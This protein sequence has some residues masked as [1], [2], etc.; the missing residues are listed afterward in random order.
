MLTLL[1]ALPDGTERIVDVLRPRV[2]IGRLPHNTISIRDTSVSREH[3]LL[4]REGAA[5]FIS[6]FRTAS[7]TWL[8]D[9]KISR[10]ELTPG[11]VVRI[12][13]ASLTVVPAPALSAEEARMVQLV[14]SGDATQR[15]VYAD[16]LEMRGAPKCAQYVRAEQAFHEAPEAN[17]QRRLK[18]LAAITSE[19]DARFRALVSRPKI[20]NCHD[21]RCPNEWNRLGLLPNA[22]VRQCDACSQK[23]TFCDDLE[24][25]RALSQ[26]GER[27][28]V[29]VTRERW[30]YDLVP[31][32]VRG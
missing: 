4:V 32:S 14:Q 20:E 25:A 19:V 1:L 11:D 28:T 23:V 3:A 13:Q 5:W 27:L 31:V 8:N 26:D 16:W 22:R 21:A 15:H 17:R 10:A 2:T 12:G 30:P 7:G 6:D 29:D 24:D 18:E 9:H